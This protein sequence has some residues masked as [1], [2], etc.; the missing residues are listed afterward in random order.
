M[1]EYHG[2]EINSHDDLHPD[3]TDI[4]YCITYEEDR[5]YIGKKAVRA[6][7]RKPP[8]KGKKRNRLIMT[9]LPFVKYQGSH[10]QAEYLTAVKKEILY[11]CRGRKA[12]TYL[13]CGLLFEHHAI[14]RDSY[15][16]ENISG[17]FFAN[18][19]DGLIYD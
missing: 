13:E 10:N 12:A 19:L 14:F 2:R 16:N 9:N 1:W 6:I 3:C 17:T 18:S 4:V 15:I 8:L 7:R 5:T 11:Q